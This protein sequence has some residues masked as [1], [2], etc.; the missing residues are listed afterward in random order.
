MFGLGGNHEADAEVRFEG[1]D[2]DRCKRGNVGFG[3]GGDVDGR[4]GGIGAGGGDVGHWM[5]REEEGGKER[6]R[7]GLD[8][9]GFGRCG[10]GVID[11]LRTRTRAQWA[12]SSH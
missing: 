3:G 10:N 4:P 5:G 1:C 2:M 6:W 7:F 11:R 8:C 9:F 12:P